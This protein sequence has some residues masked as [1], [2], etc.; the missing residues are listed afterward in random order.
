MRAALSVQQLLKQ[1]YENYFNMA[2]MSQNWE[3]LVRRGC[4]LL[5]F[6]KEKKKKWST[7]TN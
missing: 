2:I 4:A 6:P 3:N 5:P 1:V 7:H